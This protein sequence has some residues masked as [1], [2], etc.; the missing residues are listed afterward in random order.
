MQIYKNGNVI[1]MCIVCSG[2]RY[3]CVQVCSV[4]LQCAIAN[5]WSGIHNIAFSFAD[6]CCPCCHLY[7]KHLKS[8]KEIFSVISMWCKSPLGFSISVIHC[9]QI[10]KSQYRTTEPLLLPFHLDFSWKKKKKHEP[11]KVLQHKEP[12]KLFCF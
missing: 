1:R 3:V 10:Y 2:Y 9:T 5:C 8:T 4:Y 6:P 11:T 7:T 12:L